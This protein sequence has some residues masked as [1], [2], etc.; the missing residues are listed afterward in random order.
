MFGYCA[1]DIIG[2]PISILI[3]Q[4]RPAEAKNILE[5]LQRGECLKYF[6]TIRVKKD[7]TSMD[8]SLTVSPIKNDAGEVVSTSRD[9]RGAF[10]R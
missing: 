10:N 4:D 7:G 3:P 9:T 1:E 5:K 6:E 2:R 8:V